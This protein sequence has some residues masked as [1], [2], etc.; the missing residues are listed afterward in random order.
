MSKKIIVGISIP[1][2]FQHALEIQRLFTEYGCNIKTRL[3][4]HEVNENMCATCGLVVLEMVG[5]IKMIEEFIA[6]LRLIKG[7]DVQKMEF[8]KTMNN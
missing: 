1:D 4:L 7:L 5:V 2:R 6:K 8:G 3:G